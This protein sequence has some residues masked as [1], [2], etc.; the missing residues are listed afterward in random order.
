[1]FTVSYEGSFIT[2][3]LIYYMTLFY[4]EIT[5]IID[6]KHQHNFLYTLYPVQ[7]CFKLKK[8][9]LELYLR[10]PCKQHGISQCIVHTDCTFS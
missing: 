2:Y 6:S 3:V 4:S 1:M 8:I 10:T 9:L 7:G 5:F